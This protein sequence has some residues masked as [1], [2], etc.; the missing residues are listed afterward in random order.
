MSTRSSSSSGTSSSSSSSGSGGARGSP[1]IE[2]KAAATIVSMNQKP[3]SGRDECVELTQDNQKYVARLCTNAKYFTAKTEGKWRKDLAADLKDMK[4]LDLDFKA[5]HATPATRSH[6]GGTVYGARIFSEK[7]KCKEWALACW[8]LASKWPTALLNFWHTG[9]A[10]GHMFKIIV[11]LEG[12]SFSTIPLP[13]HAGTYENDKQGRVISEQELKKLEKDRKQRTLVFDSKHGS[14]L[15]KSKPKSRSVHAK[16]GAED[17]EYQKWRDLC[18]TVRKKLPAEAQKQAGEVYDI[19]IIYSATI[20][21]DHIDEPDGDGPGHIIANLCLNGDGLLVFSSESN[22]TAD[23]AG[24][25]QPPNALVAFTDELRYEATHG[26]YRVD[27]KPMKL[28]FN[29]SKPRP[30]DRIVVCIRFGK[31]P[32]R[33]MEQYN[34]LVGHKLLLEKES[35]QKEATIVDLTK[36]L[37][38]VKNELEMTKTEMSKTH[39]SSDGTRSPVKVALNAYTTSSLTRKRTNATIEPSTIFRLQ[40]TGTDKIKDYL[41]VAVGWLLVSQ[42]RKG[43]VNEEKHF[44]FW[45]LNKNKPEESLDD[46]TYKEILLLDARWVVGHPYIIPKYS[47]PSEQDSKDGQALWSS[48]KN[49]VKSTKLT[50]PRSS[51]SRDFLAS[52]YTSIYYNPVPPSPPQPPNTTKLLPL[53][54]QNTLLSSA[55]APSNAL[56]LNFQNTL[57]SSAPAPSAPLLLPPATSVPPQPEAAPRPSSVRRSSRRTSRTNSESPAAGPTPTPAPALAHGRAGTLC[58]QMMQMAPE[59]TTLHLALAAVAMEA[60]LNHQEEMWEKKTDEVTLEAQRRK[61][62]AESQRAHELAIRE[63]EDAARR[64]EKERSDTLTANHHA[65]ALKVFIVNVCLS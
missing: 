2:E 34:N 20:T 28:M 7:K 35:V 45:A 3:V 16:D 14:H 21:P 23:F 47:S 22:S 33:W 56:A 41:V 46:A 8:K 10:N 31:S 48:Y 39:W 30:T 37:N 44:V 52:S 54:F 65:L 55:S 29:L 51:K 40:E 13:K 19:T 25:Y 11:H 38:T 24:C 9:D 5:D 36:E 60:R 53:T 49:S 50:R 18:E 26:V 32:E 27:E 57:L 43:N 61:E 42:S 12:P 63:K 58:S 15:L 64:E 1:S 4:P 17:P 6:I 62:E 59:N